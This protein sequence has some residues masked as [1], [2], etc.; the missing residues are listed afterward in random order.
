[1]VARL[2]VSQL[3]IS[4]N[5]TSRRYIDNNCRGMKS[6]KNLYV[7]KLHKL[8]LLLSLKLDVILFQQMC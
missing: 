3:H 6:S 2:C 7:Y 5:Y 1:M 4:L 8:G